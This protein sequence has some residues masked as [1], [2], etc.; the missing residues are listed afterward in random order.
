[1]FT[2]VQGYPDDICPNPDH[3]RM[4]G[5][6]GGDPDFRRT[7]EMKN[8]LPYYEHMMTDHVTRRM[9]RNASMQRVAETPWSGFNEIEWLVLG[10][11]EKSEAEGL[12]T[13]FIDEQKARP[14]DGMEAGEKAWRKAVSER[15]VLNFEKAVGP[16]DHVVAYAHVYLHSDKEQRAQVHIGSDDGAAIWHNGTMIYHVEIPRPLRVGE[17]LIDVML[18]KGWN[19]FLFKVDEIEGGWALSASFTDTEGKVLEGTRLSLMPD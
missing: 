16:E 10:P 4:E 11:F 5:Q 8:W 15:G 14:K 12:S 19:S 17:N 1:M 7:P 2:A 3:G 18:V 9:W 6:F 13:P